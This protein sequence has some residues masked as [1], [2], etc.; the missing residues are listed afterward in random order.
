[1]GNRQKMQL[2]QYSLNRKLGQGFSSVVH[3][4]RAYDGKEYAIKVFDLENPKLTNRAFNLVQDEIQTT[5]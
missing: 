4:A 1:M 2:D 3:H 5:R